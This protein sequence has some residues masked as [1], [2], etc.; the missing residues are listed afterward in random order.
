MRFEADKRFILNSI[1]IKSI[2]M[3]DVGDP[4]AIKE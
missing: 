1:P 4:L 3:D 2:N